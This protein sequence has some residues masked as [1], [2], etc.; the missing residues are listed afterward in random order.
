M[1]TDLAINR[2]AI[3]DWVSGKTSPSKST[4]EKI[5]TA[6]GNT[7]DDLYVADRA[8]VYLDGH[9]IPLDPNTRHTVET[10]LRAIIRDARPDLAEKLGW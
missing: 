6:T 1:A 10:L 7:Y 2:Q 5:R 8:A 9:R 4:M 3:Y